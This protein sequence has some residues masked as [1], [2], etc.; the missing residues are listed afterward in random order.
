MAWPWRKWAG[1]GG[2]RPE[3]HPALVL[4]GSGREQ[5][6]FNQPKKILA[7]GLFLQ[8]QDIM[9][10][11]GEVCVRAGAWEGRVH[12]LQLDLE[13][14]EARATLRWKTRSLID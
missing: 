7:K 10:E 5:A 1:V 8:H 6:A 9:G 13:A 14:L 12:W 3:L 2:N 4:G 11:E